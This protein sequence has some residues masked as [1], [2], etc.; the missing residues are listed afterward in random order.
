VIRFG[1][2]NELS[3]EEEEKAKKGKGKAEG[4]TGVEGSA[5]EQEEKS[6]LL[7]RV[8]ASGEFLDF[9]FRCS[10]ERGTECD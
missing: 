9:N 6:D 1:G 2:K 7:L 5:V 8:L 4:M 3:Q 10:C